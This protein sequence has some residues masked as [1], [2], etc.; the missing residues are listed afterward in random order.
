[1]TSSKSFDIV[2]ATSLPDVATGKL[3]IGTNGS[4]P[5]SC[6]ADLR[7]FRNITS[8]TSDK[9]KQNAIIMGRKT[10]DAL[11]ALKIA[12]LPSRINIVISSTNLVDAHTYTTLNE[13]L[14]A[15][16]E[17]DD[18]ENIFVIGGGQ[19]YEAALVHPELSM[20][21]QTIVHVSCPTDAD[22]FF[23]SLDD[24]KHFERSIKTTVHE[25]SRGNPNFHVEYW[26]K[27]N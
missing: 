25:S 13:A 17:R 12:P 22:T 27:L 10:W 9:D 11:M 16:Y 23:P 15:L 26:V 1:M 19:L 7:H 14:Q 4:I 24:N 6:P 3:A 8:M 20:V 2:V 21:I 5:W 18:V